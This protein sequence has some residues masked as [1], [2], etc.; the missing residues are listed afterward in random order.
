MRGVSDADNG[1]PA[2][3]D[4]KLRMVYHQKHDGKI[5]W[6]RFLAI[7]PLWFDDAGVLQGRVTRDEEQPAPAAK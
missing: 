2:V 1:S 3:P 4:G 6:R 5:N 7:D